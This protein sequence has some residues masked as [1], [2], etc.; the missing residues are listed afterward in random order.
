LPTS[1]S[2]ETQKKLAFI[3]HAVLFEFKIMPYD[4]MNAPATYQHFLLA[5]LKWKSCLVYLDDVIVLSQSVEQHF[6]S[7]QAVFERFRKI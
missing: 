2:A 6:E 5:G 1:V 7:S 3:T 4:V